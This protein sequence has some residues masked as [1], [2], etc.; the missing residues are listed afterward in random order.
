MAR[1]YF[2]PTT[3]SRMS[4]CSSWLEAPP[5]AR[6]LEHDAAE[7]LDLVLRDAA[8]EQVKLDAPVPAVA[9]FPVLGES[10]VEV[11]F[12]APEM[13]IGVGV[14]DSRVEGGLPA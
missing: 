14:G 6:S 8:V 3:I 1:Q 2:Q 13:R 10:L 11:G 4:P 5:P 9:L 12:P 7:G